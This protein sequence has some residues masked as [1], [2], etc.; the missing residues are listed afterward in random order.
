M[1]SFERIDELLASFQVDA[2]PHFSKTVLTSSPVLLTLHLEGGDAVPLPHV[3][4]GTTHG[5]G[6]GSG[7]APSSMIRRASSASVVAATGSAGDAAAVG[8][9]TDLPD[10]LQHLLRQHKRAAYNLFLRWEHTG[11]REVPLNAFAEGV[12]QIT[13]SKL[14]DADLVAI[15]QCV[16]P[17]LGDD[18]VSDDRWRSRPIDCHRL[19]RRLQ[20][21]ASRL[22]S[23]C[24]PPI[25]R[26]NRPLTQARTRS[27]STLP[28]EPLS[29]RWPSC[30][31]MPRCTLA[32][33]SWR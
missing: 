26:T 7:C 31:R 13:G 8:D 23:K 9:E 4:V 32:I 16:D 21:S 20:S 30:S 27:H 18:V 15:L 12:R 6:A 24:V 1:P 10:A 25:G 22:A 28:A 29:A 3:A 14:T 11:Q 5:A 19:W 33:L 2:L 17:V